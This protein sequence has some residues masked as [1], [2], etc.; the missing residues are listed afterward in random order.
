M[1]DADFDWPSH[2]AALGR[3]AKNKCLAEFYHARPVDGTT[4]LDQV[5]FLAL[6]LETTGLDASD[7]AIVSMGFIPFDIHRIYCSRARHMLV[8]PELPLSER[9]ATIHSITHEKLSTAQGFN[10]HFNPLLA[11]MKHHVVVVHYH[12]IER[13]FL[14]RTV[15]RFFDDVF[16]F[17]LIDTMVI[18]SGILAAG[19]RSWFKRLFKKEK[20]PSLRLDASRARYNLPR[21]RPH[22]ALTDAVATAE[23]LMAQVRTHYPSHIPVSSLWL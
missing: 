19:Q 21:Y 11:A 2:F 7:C 8:K 12:K 9:S 22:H 15:R 18:E 3:Q 23:L 10:I 20:K 4:P 16:E 1:S 5:R 13:A 6:D 17:P 14:A